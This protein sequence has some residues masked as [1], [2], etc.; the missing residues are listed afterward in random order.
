MEK[1]MLLRLLSS[2]LLALLRRRVPGARRPRLVLR[3]RLDVAVGPPP[4]PEAARSP[5]EHTETKT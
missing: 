3:S 4:A 1:S 2:M 5:A